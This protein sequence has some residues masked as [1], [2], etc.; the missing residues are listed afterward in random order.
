MKDSKEMTQEEM[1]AELLD[2]Y[3]HFTPDEQNGLMAFC[4]L[5]IEDERG[6]LDWWAERS[7]EEKAELTRA[8]RERIEKQRQERQGQAGD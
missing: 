5:D 7:P 8:T 3:R 2:L 6:P 4:I 1:I